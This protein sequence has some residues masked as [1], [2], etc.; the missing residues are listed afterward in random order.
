[1]KKEQDSTQELPV[2]IY[3]SESKSGIFKTFRVL[4]KEFPVA[5]SLG[6]RFAKRNIS[7]KYRQSIFGLL[8]AF[9]PPLAT[10]IMW[11]ILQSMKVIKL[12]DVGVPYPL[13]VVTGTMLWAVFVNSVLTPMQVVQ[14]NKSILVKINFPREALIVNAFYEILFTTAINS[15]IIVAFLFIFKV[16]ITA[17][18][19]LFF[20]GIFLLIILG[21]A[22]GLLILPFSLL[23]RDIQFVLPTILQFAMYLTPVIYATT[24]FKGFA[25]ILKINPVT[26]V[27]TEIR[28]AVLNMNIHVP[29]WEIGVVGALAVIFFILGVFLQRITMQTLIERMGN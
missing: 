6:L 8:W 19:L 18:C 25:K 27:L 4:I 24:P 21:M 15:L 28:A 13:F 11:I 12:N 1:M 5:H 29:Y 9:L 26:P 23:Y 17:E 7:T 16:H 14:N 2:H 20:P 22:I 10:A 3:S